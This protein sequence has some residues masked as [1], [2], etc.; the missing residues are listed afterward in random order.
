VSRYD[1]LN[2][3]VTAV[4]LAATR[5]GKSM[6]IITS[7]KRQYFSGTDVNTRVPTF[8]P[9]TEVGILGSFRQ[10]VYVTLAG[11]VGQD[12]SE[13][14]ITFNPLVRWVWLGGALMAL[15]GLIVMWPQA[16]RRQ[17]QGGYMTTLQPET[18]SADAV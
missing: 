14:R 2:R 5:D 18:A 12:S 11:V 3:E 15:G 8:Q 1:V 4:A 16:E 10:D 9:S 13:I 7:E 6:G 17:R